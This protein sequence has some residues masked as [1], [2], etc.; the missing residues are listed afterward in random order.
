MDGVSFLT[1]GMTV[2][3]AHRLFFKGK[4]EKIEAETNFNEAEA[5]V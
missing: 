5:D 2:V 1:D 3:I 4:E